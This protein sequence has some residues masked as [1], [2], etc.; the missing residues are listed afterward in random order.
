[1]I[2]GPGHTDLAHLDGEGAG[3]DGP[4]KQQLQLKVRHLVISKQR[5]LL[6]AHGQASHLS[7]EGHK[8][9]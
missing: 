2:A 4:L 1:M 3:E 6:E 8:R 5:V 7:W 9:K